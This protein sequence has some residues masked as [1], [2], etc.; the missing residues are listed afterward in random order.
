MSFRISLAF[1]GEMD[2]REDVV[3]DASLV[4]DKSQSNFSVNIQIHYNNNLRSIS[5]TFIL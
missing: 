1:V 2:I 3:K 5:L 4:K